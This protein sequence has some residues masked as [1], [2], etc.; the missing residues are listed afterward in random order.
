MSTEKIAIL[1]DST[2]DLS[3]ELIEK[4]EVGILPFLVTLGT[5]SFRDGVDIS[6][7]QIFDYVASTG[8]LPKTGAPSVEEYTEFFKKYVDDGYKVIYFCISGEASSA[9]SFAN[10][11][12]KEFEEGAVYAVDSR[13]L[14]TGI[15]LLV[16]KAVELKNQGLT[17]SKIVEKID[18]LKLK[19]QTSFVVDTLDYLAKGGMCS[20]MANIGG[21]LL[22]IHP[23]IIMPNGKLISDKKY[24]FSKMEKVLPKYVEDLS[25]KYTS[26]DT[27]RCFITHSMCAPEIVEKVKEKVK[28]CFNFEEIIETTAGSVITSHCGQGTLGLLFIT[29]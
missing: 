19:T 1:A 24:M 21:K 17:A 26:Y 5:D 9:Y 22:G 14:S 12:S 8:V 25:R 4:N 2:C 3:K 18:E 28:A 13:H 16:L 27:T 15:G 29:N 6:P 7:Q 11:A 23:M 20:S 10:L